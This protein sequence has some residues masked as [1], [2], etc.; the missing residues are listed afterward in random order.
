VRRPL[1][2]MIGFLFLASTAFAGN[3]K[4]EI[5]ATTVLNSDPTIVSGTMHVEDA[6]DLTF[7]VTYDETEVGNVVSAAVTLLVSYDGTNFLAANFYDYAGGSTLQT[8]ETLSTDGR[9]YFVLDP[10]VPAPY[11]KVTIT[12][13]NTDA[14]DTVAVTCNVFGKQ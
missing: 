6:T 2:L 14:D 9:Y 4:G 8:T 5:I 3:F 12:G 13:T 11:V 10:N 7:F 1:G